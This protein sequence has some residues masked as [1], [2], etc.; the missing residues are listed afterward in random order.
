MM[1]IFDKGDSGDP[2][3]A[4]LSIVL[5]VGLKEIARDSSLNTGIGTGVVDGVTLG[6][7]IRFCLPNVRGIGEID[8]CSTQFESEIFTKLTF[9]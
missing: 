5:R 3:S 6:S 7:M 4:I 8:V 9:L 1:F 2:I